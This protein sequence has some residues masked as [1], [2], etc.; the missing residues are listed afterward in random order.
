[1]S[2]HII[3]SLVAFIG[4]LASTLL[5]CTG[6]SRQNLDAGVKSS[7]E[8]SFPSKWHVF[9]NPGLNYEPTAE[10]FNSIPETL[11]GVKS[12]EKTLEN[13]AMNLAKDF[14]VSN[15]RQSA[16]LFAEMA[17]EE[18]CVY[19]MGCG[20]DW[21]FECFVNGKSVYSTFAEG[22]QFYPP[23]MT[24]HTFA[25][26]LRKGGNVIAIKYRSGDASSLVAIGGGKELINPKL[27]AEMQARKESFEARDLKD[28]IAKGLAPEGYVI[29]SYWNKLLLPKISKLADRHSAVDKKGTALFTAAE[30]VDGAVRLKIQATPELSDDEEIFVILY[31][32]RWE[33][34]GGRIGRIGEFKK[35]VGADG[36]T[37]IVIPD[38]FKMH[39]G[40]SVDGRIKAGVCSRTNTER[41][42]HPVQYS[43]KPY[44]GDQA[45]LKIEETPAGPTPMLD[46]KPFFFNCFTIHPFI[47]ERTIPTGMEGKNSPVNVVAARFG[48]NGASE[49]WWYGP[50][51]YD[52]TTVDWELDGL[53]R[54]FPDSK[55]AIYL[56]CHPG[57]WYSEKYPER[58]SKDQNGEAVIDYYVSKVR[59]S[60]KDVQA[61]TLKAVEQFVK[62]CEKFFGNRIVIY[63]LM[64]GISC[65]WQGWNSH[66]PIFADYSE[67]CL[68]D[69]REYAAARGIKVDHIPTPEEHL[70]SDGGIFRNPVKDANVM[71]YD[72]F[73]SEA[74]ANFID[75]IAGTIKANCDGNKLV[76]CYYGYHQEYANMGNTTNRGGHNATEMI[77]ASPNVDFLLSPQSY[78]IRALG[79]PNADMKPYGAARIANKFSIMEDDTRTHKLDQCGYNQALNQE[80]TLQLLKRN[81]GMYLCHRMPINQLGEHGGDEMATPEL[82]DFYAKTLK[83]GQYIME[84]NGADPTEIAA[85]IDEEAIQYLTTRRSTYSSED[86][87]SCIYG[88]D[89]RLTLNPLRS[90]IPISGESIG[91]Q[92]FALAQAGAPV[93]IILL[94]DVVKTAG[95]YKVVFFLNS[96]KDT[97]ELRDAFAA[98][99]AK[100][101]ATV[102]VHGAGFIDDKGFSAE[103][104][105]SLI[106]MEMSMLKPGGISV[107]MP[108]GRIFGAD[109]DVE[110]RFTVSDKEAKAYA[111]YVKGGAVAVANKGKSYFYGGAALSP[112]YIRKVARENGVHV[113]LET[114]DNLYAGANCISIHAKSKGLKKISL[115]RKCTVVDVYSGE[116][117]AKDADSFAIDMQALESR[118]F[119][120]K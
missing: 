101:V 34:L 55:I 46:G 94:D 110:P 25:V 62:H 86:D 93:D 33:E 30:V 116:T 70:R 3:K 104:M 51:Q 69:F 32:R 87:S 39:Y 14:G 112:E 43:L 35:S 44:P 68:N 5:V 63:N 74:I 114:G 96:Y 105:S 81:V 17:S 109:Y 76:G 12:I 10:E 28:K 16:W 29:D 73:Y 72:R 4:M 82:Y 90:A 49:R 18:D 78:S 120:L 84:Q 38:A 40:E 47:P 80:Q 31:S 85:V 113:Y 2:K 6:C 66:S 67:G 108:D 111:N 107:R 65:E 36:V 88:Y 71:L 54:Q 106:G 58:L 57:N 89:G 13:N 59:F 8:P 19:Q 97:P 99:K 42:D 26:S 117:V 79:A 45:V 22:N 83:A 21:W 41:Y 15:D 37:E 115:P 1:M 95:K 100:G 102:V 103:S 50:D 119:L 91:L 48:G 11:N 75:R 20:A 27:S 23:Q 118:V 61:D 53:V 52:F 7:S 98:L 64:G 77:L 9:L 92:R 24:D 56:W 60:D